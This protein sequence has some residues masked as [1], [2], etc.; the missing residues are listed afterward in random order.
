MQIYYINMARRTDRRAFMEAQLAK[1]GLEATRIE[2]VTPETFLASAVTASRG[3]LTPVALSC[4]L[5]HVKAA[6]ALLASGDPC[7]LILEDDAIL[8]TRLPE[9]LAALDA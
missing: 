8:S 3:R 6:E 1:L 5:S 9:F 7:A 4:S 2:A